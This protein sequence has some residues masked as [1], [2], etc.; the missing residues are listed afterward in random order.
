MIFVELQMTLMCS[1][2]FLL[3]LYFYWI[4]LNFALQYDHWWSNKH[5]MF[6]HEKYFIA[7]KLSVESA[8]QSIRTIK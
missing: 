7:P 2:L 5:Q 8:I 6:S 1:F 3:L 4:Y